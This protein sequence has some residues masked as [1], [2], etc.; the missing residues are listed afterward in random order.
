MQKMAIKGKIP[1]PFYPQMVERVTQPPISI[2]VS[3]LQ[4]TNPDPPTPQEPIRPA[5]PTPFDNMYT[6][7]IKALPV[8]APQVC[9]YTAGNPHGLHHQPTPFE[10][11][12]HCPAPLLTTKLLPAGRSESTKL[13]QHCC[14]YCRYI[15]HWNNQCAFPHTKCHEAGK[16]VVLLRHRAFNWACEYGGWTPA[17]HPDPDTMKAQKRKHQVETEDLNHPAGAANTPNNTPVDMRLPLVDSLLFAPLDP[18]TKSFQP[19]HYQAAPPLGTW[20]NAPWGARWDEY[21]AC[22]PSPCIFEYR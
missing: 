4:V 10:D 19:S 7:T 3:T 13:M 16:C 9:N 6:P 12:H 14:F 2:L 15:G 21:T 18:L 20:G 5:N 8:P 17:N 1:D 11:D 22:H